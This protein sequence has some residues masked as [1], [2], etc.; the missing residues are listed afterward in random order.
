MLVTCLCFKNK[1]SMNNKR[2]TNVFIRDHITLNKLVLTL[3]YERWQSERYWIIAHLKC[4]RLCLCLM[5]V[6]VKWNLNDEQKHLRL[7]VF[8]NITTSCVFI[9]VVI[10]VFITAF[11]VQR[12]NP[13]L[14]Q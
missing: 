8:E 3:L 4:D 13:G 1:C 6:V 9:I 11:G 7:N 14:R 10:N 5:M 2:C 12:P